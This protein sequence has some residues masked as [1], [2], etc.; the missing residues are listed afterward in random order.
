MVSVEELLV[1]ANF[2][3]SMSVLKGIVFD[4]QSACI[5]E[6]L[7]LLP[8]GVKVEIIDDKK[9]LNSPLSGICHLLEGDCGDHFMIHIISCDKGK[10]FSIVYMLPELVPENIRV[11]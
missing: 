1:L 4:H 10:I 6:L 3:M 5:S 11:I 9:C 2:H 7:E 8:R